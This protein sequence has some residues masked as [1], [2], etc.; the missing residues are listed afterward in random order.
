MCLLGDS[1]SRQAESEDPPPHC[2][3]FGSLWNVVIGS[4]LFTLVLL[5][6]WTQ[7]LPVHLLY[8]SRVRTPLPYLVH[9]W[10]FD[11]QIFC[12]GRLICFSSYIGTESPSEEIR[13]CLSVNLLRVAWETQSSI[14]VRL[15]GPS[16]HWEISWIWSDLQRLRK[17]YQPRLSYVSHRT[18]GCKV[19]EGGTVCAN[20]V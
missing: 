11:S 4:V 17:N 20:I 7:L 5:P 19:T 18:R 12:S 2:L 14:A 9:H 6:S 10:S 8:I 15:I 16:C 3:S 13:P 1:K